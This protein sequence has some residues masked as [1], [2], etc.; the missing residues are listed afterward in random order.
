MS[1]MYLQQNF[2]AFLTAL[3]HLL[4]VDIK[5]RNYFNN[6][7]AYCKIFELNFIHIIFGTL[8]QG[9]SEFLLTTAGNSLKTPL[10]GKILAVSLAQI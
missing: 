4:T 2:L 6:F 8:L 5:L 7:L 1:K 9:P 3:P 10:C